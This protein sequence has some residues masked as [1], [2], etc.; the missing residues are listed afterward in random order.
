MK[1]RN[2]ICLIILLISTRGFGQEKPEAPDLKSI[3]KTVSDKTSE[4]YYPLLFKRFEEGDATMTLSEKR[5][6]YYGY[7]TSD[8]YSAY[9]SSR[10]SDSVR[11]ILKNGTLLE[12]DYIRLLSFTDSALKDYPMD[13]RT[14]NYRS[15][16]ARQLGDK[17][18]GDLARAKMRLLVDAILSTGDGR[19]A[20]TAYWVL[21]VGHEYF[22][23]NVLDLEYGGSQSLVAGPCDYLTVKENN[24]GLKGVYFNVN[25]SFDHM[26]DLFDSPRKGKGKRK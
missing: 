18:A 6:L 2:L 23:L 4:L 24:E 19:T 3:K 15:Y 17:L 10:F 20:N 8:K 9:P 14:L 25:I 13:L 26:S 5:H 7:T 16:A 12:A 1:I 21:E 22:M 11:A